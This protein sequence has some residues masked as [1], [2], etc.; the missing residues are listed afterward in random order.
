[1]VDVVSELKGLRGRILAKHRLDAEQ[2]DI[3]DRAIEE[4]ESLER[5][6]AVTRPGSGGVGDG[7]G[8]V[9]LFDG[10]EIDLFGFLSPAKDAVTEE[11]IYD[12]RVVAGKR[13]NRARAYAA[14]KVY[15]RELREVS[16][17]AVIFETGETKAADAASVRSSLGVL[18]RY[19]DEWRRLH[20]RISYSGELTPD[21]AMVRLLMD[22]WSEVAEEASL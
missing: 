11:P 16:L 15:G 19:G 13:N 20:G 4:A 1:M 6:G 9:A 7:D 14:A 21:Y 10:P 8:G 12:V 17:A 2:I 3:L 18:V 22:E 5:G